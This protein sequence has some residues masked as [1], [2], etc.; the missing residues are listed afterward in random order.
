MGGRERGDGGRE[1]R[2]RERRGRERR[3]RERGEGASL[4][5]VC[6][7]IKRALESTELKMHYV[8]VIYRIIR[9]QLQDYYRSADALG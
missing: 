8:H 6:M 3:G 9:A 5:Q 4:N 1:G 2:E 7:F